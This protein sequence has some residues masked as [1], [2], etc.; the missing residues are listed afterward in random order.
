[1]PMAT[2]STSFLDTLAVN[3][4]FDQGDQYSDLAKGIEALKYLGIDTI[5]EAANNS[6]VNATLADAGMKFDFFVY[7][8]GTPAAA[9]STIHTFAAAHPGA[10]VSIEGPNEVDLWPVNY[11]GKTGIAG[12]QAFQAD[13]F[14]AVN[15]DAL[16][17]DLPVYN[18]SWGVGAP[19]KSGA[20]DVGNIH[21]YMGSG[22]Q[23][24]GDLPWWVNYQAAAMPGKP[25]VITETGYYTAPQI[26]PTWGGVDGTTQAK[27]ILNTF[28]RAD[29]M[30]IGRTFVY[31]LLDQYQDPA[32]TNREAHFG[33]FDVNFAPKPAATALHNLT[34]I[35][36]DDSA[37]AGSFAPGA[38]NYSVSGL[39]TSGATKLLEKASGIFDLVVWAEPDI[40]DQTNHQP[41]AAATSQVVVNLGATF[42]SVTIFD[43]MKGS[44]AQQVLHDV[45]QITLGVTDSPL[46]I[47][48][49]NAV[50][51]SGTGTSTGTP[52][53]STTLT[54]GSGTDS[55]VLKV[56][57]DV[58][59][60]SAQYTVAVDGQT[61]GGIL[62]ATA[63]AGSG[64][65]D[66]VTVKGDWAAG[67]HSVVMTFLNDAWGGTSTTDLNLYLD[68]ATYNG[69]AV[70]GAKLALF[71]AGPG[72]I[73]F[74]EVPPP[75]INGTTAA[76][77]LNGT[78]QGDTI[79][80]LGGNDTVHGNDGNDT[81]NGGAGADRLFG[82]AG[83]DHIVGGA[84]ADILTGA[85]GADR[86]VYLSVADRGDRITDF[87]AA[88]SDRIDVSAIFAAGPHAQASLVSGGYVKFVQGSTGA[89]LW[90]DAD[91]G[92]NSWYKL[93]TLTGVTV[94]P[95]LDTILIA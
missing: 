82:N 90:V 34:T 49:S 16:L 72:T 43:P 39:P 17:K 52:P 61:I 8:G 47:E 66:T 94:G 56:S 24:G 9:V 53:A 31:Q 92:A 74:T 3:T 29:A 63:T 77:T 38:L 4:H 48:V 12:A 10:V 14:N 27:E 78:A 42:S 88:D 93:V 60:G 44:G 7:P 57:Q 6:A 55:L 70:P 59:Q 20:A 91:G 45:Q 41:I 95:Q 81:I 80:A 46:I 5:R 30:G 40:W 33:L 71:S 69:A 13:L 32:G 65:S 76:D 58:Y 1:M 83:N 28:F 85:A 11:A 87:T 89:S 2:R 62:T 21:A 67:A 26:D 23:P 84:G 35:L 18:F 51:T 25:L 15:A 22:N 54:V 37:N 50:T 73:S 79:N 36:A 19:D 68:S 64:L 86:F 75:G